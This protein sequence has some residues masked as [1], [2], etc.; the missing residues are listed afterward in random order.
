MASQK[1][2]IFSD[3]KCKVSCQI[4]FSDG[5]P[6]VSLFD[7]R[8]DSVE[9]GKST[10]ELSAVADLVSKAL[11]EIKNAPLTNPASNNLPAP[12]G[13]IDATFWEKQ[14]DW[15]TAPEWARC[16][17]IH[18]DAQGFYVGTWH[19]Y[20]PAVCYTDMNF[21]TGAFMSVW[22]GPGRKETWETALS[23]ELPWEQSL[24]AR[25]GSRFVPQ[26]SPLTK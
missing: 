13:K 25:P 5:E 21:V 1:R 14:Y 8:G 19:E 22:E 9:I 2:I 6:T 4:K 17:T 24:R 16:A 26:N 10:V 23:G 7:E 12:A 11:H 18:R 20:L 3:E 15:R